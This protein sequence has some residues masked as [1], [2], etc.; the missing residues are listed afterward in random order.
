[1]CK[2]IL[3]TGS[4]GFLGSEICKQ[5]REKNIKAICL[6]RN[7]NKIKKNKNIKWIRSSLRISKKNYKI[8]K[9]FEPEYIFHLAWNK[10]PLFD[11]KTCN[12][13]LLESSNFL[14][15]I[16]DIKSIKKIA[17][18]GS[19]AEYKHKSGIKKESH[20][21]DYKNFFSSS[22]NLL[23]VYA[24][25]LC[26]KK[27]IKLDW[28]RIFYVYGINQRKNSFIP[29][30]INSI[31]KKKGIYIK[32]PDLKLDYINVIDVANIFFKIL[33]INFKSGVYNLGTGKSSSLIYILNKILSIIKIKDKKTF[34]KN[35]SLGDKKNGK[36]FVAC[37]RKSKK[38]FK[39]KNFRS[40]QYS[41][42]EIIN[43]EY[44]R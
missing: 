41:L 17:I 39:I 3:I 11:K 42:K 37:M 34:L 25:N 18:S 4:T 16:T 30:I 32:N 26:Q 36:E 24:K 13:N 1:M 6:Y 8:I 43:F 29:T 2:K 23:F 15:K 27:N 35:L 38:T 44:K 5:L 22:K 20:S 40:I 31:N 7:K 19:C 33:H 14:D 21:L 28:F 10:I 12:N 9:K